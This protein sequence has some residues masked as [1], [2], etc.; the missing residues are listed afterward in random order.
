MRIGIAY[1][2]QDDYGLNKGNKS[3]RY[4]FSTL[5]EISLLKNTFLEANHDVVLLKGMKY[6]ANNITKIKRNVDLIF[7]R[8][9][10]YNNRNREGT[11]QSLFEIYEIPYVGSDAYA[12]SLTMNKAHTK[13]IAS[14]LGVLTPQFVFI[15]STDDLSLI[16]KISFFPILVKPTGDVSSDGIYVCQNSAEARQK[17]YLLISEFNQ[18]VLCEKY[19]AGRDISVSVYGNGKNRK[20]LGCI[21]TLEETGNPPLIYGL[22]EKFF[23]NMRKEIPCLNDDITRLINRNCMVL[24]DELQL[25]DLSR[26]DFRYGIDGNPYFL[27]INTLPAIDSASSF[28]T[29]ITKQGLDFKTIM[30]EIID[31]A[32]Q[33]YE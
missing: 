24:C 8:I 16:D 4:D 12:C 2:M 17:A 19:I 10:G 32:V 27:E 20:V 14:H 9:E 31:A 23:M 1:D 7:N 5:E 33:R 26:F 18:P 15:K 22:Q 6:I 29:C 11:I 21:E 25:R 13:I 30:T 28:Y 3:Y